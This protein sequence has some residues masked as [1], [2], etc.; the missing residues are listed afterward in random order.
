VVALLVAGGALPAK[1]GNTAP[2]RLNVELGSAAGLAP[3]GQSL[4]ISLLAS[5]PEQWAVLQALVTVSQPQASGQATFPLTCTGLLQAFRVTVQS[6]GA[7]FQL[8]EAQASALVLIKRGRTEQA[9]DSQ[10]VQVEPTVVVDL[11]DTALLEGRGEAVL[12]EVT[13]ACPVGA[14]GQHVERSGDLGYVVSTVIL[15]IPTADGQPTTITFNDVTV[16][17]TDA[18]GGWRVVVDSA[19]RTAPLKTPPPRSGP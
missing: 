3:D 19:N 1:A 15:E 16:W 14:T 18:D 5:C 13:A 9:Q 7:P 17:R 2:T 4:N 6:P 12:I 8:G 11:A 10:V